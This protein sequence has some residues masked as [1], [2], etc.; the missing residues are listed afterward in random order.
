[1]RRR[2]RRHIS[3]V[4]REYAQTKVRDVHV[5]CPQLYCVQEGGRYESLYEIAFC[6]KYFKS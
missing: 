3:G 2:L 5:G 6:E 4:D 1:M